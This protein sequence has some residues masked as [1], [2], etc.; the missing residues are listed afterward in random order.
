MA[1]NRGVLDSMAGTF[2]N[3]TLDNVSKLLDFIAEDWTDYRGSPMSEAERR[4][5]IRMAQLDCNH[6]RRLTRLAQAV[7]NKVQRG[8][9]TREEA[10]RLNCFEE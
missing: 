5:A 6:M 3:W 4:R 2:E 8:E 10:R 7:V 9:M 1:K